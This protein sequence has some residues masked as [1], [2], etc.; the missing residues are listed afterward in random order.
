MARC[1][2]C[3]ADLVGHAVCPRCGTLAA[4]EFAIARLRTQVRRVVG[5]RVSSVS[6]KLR[7]VHFFWVCAVMP[8]VLVPPIVS[9]ISA[10][11]AMRR[12]SEERSALNFEWIA[13]VS[14]VNLILSS[15]ALYKFHFSPGEVFGFAASTARA[16]LRFFLGLVPGSPSGPRIT[17]V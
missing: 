3:G 2:T 13:I 9:L 6:R 8:L 7:P 11:A 10:I 16:L 12:P 17:P 1:P 5:E 14:V 4:A 15:L